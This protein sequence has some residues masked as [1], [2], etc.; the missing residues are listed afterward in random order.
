MLD[1]DVVII[2]GTPAGRQAAL[3]ATQMR[4]RVALVEP[5]PVPGQIFGPNSHHT[6]LQVA[7]VARQM[8]EMPQFGISWETATR[9][10][11]GEEDRSRWENINILVRPERTRRWMECVADHMENLFDPAVLASQGVDVIFGK[12][13]FTTAPKLAFVVNDRRLRSRT[14][15]L[16]TGSQARLPDAEGLP[17]TGYLSADTVGKL[18][19]IPARVAVIGGDPTGAE[20]AQT[21][22]RLGSQVT[23]VTRGPQILARED[24]EATFLVQAQLEAE[25]VTVFTG[26]PVIQARQIEESKWIQAGN[27]AIEVDEI[28]LAA[29]RTPQ[30]GGLNLEGVG[31]QLHP[32]RLILNEKLQTTNPRIYACGAIA[33]GYPLPHV[34]EYESRVALKNALYWPRFRVNYHGI[35][36]VIH[37]DPPLARVGLTQKQAR[38]RYGDRVR[39]SRETF[40]H[41]PKAQLSGETTGFCELVGHRDGRILGASIFGVGAD[42]SINF[43]AIAIREGLK[44]DAIADFPAVWPSLAGVAPQ[45]AAAWVRDCRRPLRSDW[46]EMLFDWR[47]SWGS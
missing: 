32:D 31:V 37:T 2:G 45:T 13:E 24:P 38:R 15:L 4:A 11:E 20:L 18:T 42:E 14:Y 33:G 44:M 34:A 17:L 40:R 5:H 12:G 7:R 22:V 36:W 43:V 26:T 1:Y 29:G 16:A 35:P 30:V 23:L 9:A 21:F 8:R 41:V 27:R 19:H 6:L 47:R 28:I 25:G 10:G 39:V 46:L 3:T